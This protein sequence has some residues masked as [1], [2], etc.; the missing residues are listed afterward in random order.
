M[1]RAVLLFALVTCSSSAQNNLDSLVKAKIAGF[2][3]RVSLYAK[4]LKTG[5]TYSINGADPVRTASTIKLAIMAECFFER[6]EGKLNFDQRL[7]LT[8]A[9]KVTGSGV[10]TELSS[11]IKLPVRDLI[12]LMIVVSDNTAANL[13]LNRIT[14]EAVNT[15]MANLGLT[16]TRVMRNILGSGTHPTGVTQEGR[17]PENAKWGTG[18]SS[19]RE[20]VTLLDMLYRG[21]LVDK[22]ASGEMLAILKRQQLRSGIARDLPDL[23]VASK[24]GTL[25]HLRS[26]VGIVYTPRGDVAMAITV[27]DIPKVFYSDD[28]P[29][30]LLIS[31]L[32]DI[33]L[34]GLTAK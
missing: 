10:L 5:A 13:I 21:K 29:G 20:M 12:H 3:G 31:A 7:E 1:I 2:Q 32:S 23:V 25:D 17:K 26:G 30:S 15:R 16:Q 28:N 9:G 33:L 8:S 18:R 24:S 34:N 19:P 6:A 14:G 11:G 22:A 4:N 27:D